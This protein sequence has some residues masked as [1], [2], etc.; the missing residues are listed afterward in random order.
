MGW[1]LQEYDAQPQWLLKGL[2]MLWNSRVEA[3]KQ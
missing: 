1:T 3:T 2:M